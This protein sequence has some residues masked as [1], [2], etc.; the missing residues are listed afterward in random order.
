MGCKGVE[1]GDV[2]EAE[3]AEGVLEDRY[4]GVIRG[5]GVV[6]R[7][8]CLDDFVDLRGYKRVLMVSKMDIGKK[9]LIRLT[10]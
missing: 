1:C 10:G 2:G 6:V 9:G 4:S 3:L 7:V 5:G 8:D